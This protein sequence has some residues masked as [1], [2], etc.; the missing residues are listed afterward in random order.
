MWIFHIIPT[1]KLSLRKGKMPQRG[2]NDWVSARWFWESESHGKASSLES[3]GVCWAS[4]FRAQAGNTLFLELLNH[5]AGRHVGWW[6]EHPLE[7]RA[8]QVASPTL[9]VLAL[10]TFLHHSRGGFHTSTIGTTSTSQG[11]AERLKWDNAY[12][13][14]NPISG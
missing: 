3:C 12:R 8:L 9:E 2:C 6:S 1:F 5:N 7:V 13:L 4:Q 14:L 11:D 10:G